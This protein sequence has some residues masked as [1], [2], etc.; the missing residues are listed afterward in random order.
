MKVDSVLSF[1]E[2]VLVLLIP[3]KIKRILSE[4]GDINFEICYMSSNI[5]FI[6]SCIWASSN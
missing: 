3:N 6:E 2:A 4:L 5:T 1:S